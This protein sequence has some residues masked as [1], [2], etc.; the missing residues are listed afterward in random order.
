L[1][2]GVAWQDT[3]GR[4]FGLID[5][6]QFEQAFRRRMRGVLPVLSDAAEAIDGKTI[7]RSGGMDATALHLVS[8]VR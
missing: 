3:F 8:T 7:R 2:H 6:D 4:V 1:Q 5:P